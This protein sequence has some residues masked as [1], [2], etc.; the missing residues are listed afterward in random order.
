MQAQQAANIVYECRRC[1][2]YSAQE[3]SECPN[4]RRA[5]TF[6]AVRRFM[7]DA[8]HA[9]EPLYVCQNCRHQSTEL[10]LT[11]PGCGKLRTLAAVPVVGY[12]GSEYSTERVVYGCRNL[13]CPHRSEQWTEK[14]PRCGKAIRTEAELNRLSMICGLFFVGMGALVLLIGFVVA[15]LV[16]SQNEVKTEAYGAVAL[17]FGIGLVLAVG[18]LSGIKG[19]WWLIHVLTGFRD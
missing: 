17:V 3:L 12:D 1:R 11:C 15:V 10:L 4:C 18:G 8:S 6:R 13:F 5:K 7:P 9:A 2:Y 19:H 16:F 14:C